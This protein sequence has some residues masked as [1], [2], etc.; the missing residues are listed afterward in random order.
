MNIL[1]IAIRTFFLLALGILIAC[2]SQKITTSTS[3]GP[4]RS[5]E[6]RKEPVPY[7][8]L[9]CFTRLDGQA[10][11]WAPDAKPFHLESDFTA[12]STGQNGE[13]AVWRGIF[14]SATRRAAKYFTCSGSREPGAPVF[15][16]SAN[17]EVPYNPK[18]VLFDAFLLKVNSDKAFAVAQQ[19]GGEGLLKKDPQQPVAYVLEMTR[20]QGVPYWYVVY[21]KDLKS[22]KGIGVVNA[23]TGAFVRAT[24]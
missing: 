20:D 21:G 5:D 16:L 24:K 8:A 1:R 12:E 22:N 9:E 10:H 15:G 6:T 11:L 23:T 17:M 13:S 19:H 7:T 4:K 2:S 14:A 18:F 3:V